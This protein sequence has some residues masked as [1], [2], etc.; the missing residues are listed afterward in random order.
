VVRFERFGGA[1]GV[2]GAA[3]ISAAFALAGTST[4]DGDVLLAHRMR[5]E[6]LTVLRIVG[7]LG[8][9]WFTAALAARLRQLG[10]RPSSPARFVYGAGLLWG[11]VWL[12]S[13]S[14]NSAAISMATTYA[15]PRAVR[16]LTVLGV[17]SVLVLTPA[18]TIALL[19]ATG[20]AVL[21]APTFPRR[22]GYTTLVSAAFR[23]VLALLDWYGSA[24]LAMRIMMITLIWVVITGVH[25]LGATRS[26]PATSELTA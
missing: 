22:F 13:A 4:P 20:V 14:F 26:A 6:S 9:I 16:F 11:S 1:S 3:A 8:I 2:I 21:A 25:L 7:G 5:W 19:T 17:Q 15:D 24:E 18:L 23:L 12:V 10:A